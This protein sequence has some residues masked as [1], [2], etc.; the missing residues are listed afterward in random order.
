VA[1]DVDHEAYDQGLQELQRRYARDALRVMI[2][3]AEGTEFVNVPAGSYFEVKLDWTRVGE[4]PTVAGLI[5]VLNIIKTAGTAT[6]FDVKILAKSAGSG[7][8]ELF[9]ATG[10]TWPY[11]KRFDAPG[12][13]WYSED[14]GADR[15]KFVI[16]IQPTGGT[17]TGQARIYGRPLR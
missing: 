16:A 14:S 13:S 2:A 3:R 10:L 1:T 4:V 11:H 6:G 15:G 17:F 8:D 7:L 9:V 12:L 5:E